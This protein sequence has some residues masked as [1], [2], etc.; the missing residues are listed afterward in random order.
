MIIA[1]S[2]DEIKYTL[3]KDNSCAVISAIL[4]CK[5]TPLSLSQRERERGVRALNRADAEREG[6][7]CARAGRARPRAA[8]PVILRN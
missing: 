5:N 1:P 3:D 6:E 7:V 2:S 8:V 4:A